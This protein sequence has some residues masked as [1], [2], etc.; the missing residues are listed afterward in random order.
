MEPSSWS[1]LESEQKG[2]G[3]RRDLNL[4]WKFLLD[5]PIQS[6]LFFHILEN[7]LKYQNHNN[8]QIELEIV[9]KQYYFLTPKSEIAFFIIV[10]SILLNSVFFLLFQRICS[11]LISTISYNIPFFHKLRKIIFCT[12]KL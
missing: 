12:R 1:A 3:R 10:S 5:F 6:V 11:I 9:N 8:H 7:Q 2:K 4:N